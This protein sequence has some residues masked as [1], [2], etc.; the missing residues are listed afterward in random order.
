MGSNDTRFSNVHYN[1]RQKMIEDILETKQGSK[2]NERTKKVANREIV[3][4]E[5][6]KIFYADDKITDEDYEKQAKELLTLDEQVDETETKNSLKTV[7][8]YWASST[9]NIVGATSAATVAVATTFVGL[10]GWSF[11]AAAGAYGIAALVA[12]E[13]NNSKKAVKE[14]SKREMKKQLKLEKAAKKKEPQTPAAVKLKKDIHQLHNTA[15]THN[16]LSK[17]AK[18]TMSQIVSVVDD[19]TENY[20]LVENNI[21]AKVSLENIVNNY[22]PSSVTEYV[23]LPTSYAITAKIK[24]KSTPREVFE[25][26]LNIIH[27]AVIEIRD[28]VYQSNIENLALQASFLAGK[29]AKPKQELSIE[30]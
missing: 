3:K 24:G 5:N 20:D 26:N 11:L 14:I 30:S 2:Y 10:S 16:R 15:Y 13:D 1:N 9:K 29:F 6:G 27:G 19:I 22:L 25:S 7:F 28:N 12:P 18:E 23:A 21:E 17:E 8:S 4:K